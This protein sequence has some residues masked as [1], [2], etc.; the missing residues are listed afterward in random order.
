MF[1]LRCC[2]G[3]ASLA[4]IRD[5]LNVGNMGE[6]VAGETFLCSVSGHLFLTHITSWPKSN[7]KSILVHDEALLRMFLIRRKNLKTL[8]IYTRVDFKSF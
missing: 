2:A 4:D 8:N 7:F 3:H 1:F 6:D 5:S